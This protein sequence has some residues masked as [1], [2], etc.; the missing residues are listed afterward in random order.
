MKKQKKKTFINK[1]ITILIVLATLIIGIGYASV[2]SVILNINGNLMAYQYDGLFI[3][4]VTIDENNTF[5]AT[6]SSNTANNTIL[7]TSISLGN[8]LS[9]KLTMIVNVCNKYPDARIFSD[10]R[11]M[12]LTEEELAEYPDLLALYT[13]NDIII[14]KSSYSNLAG[15]VLP[16]NSCM[17]IPVTFKYSDSLS[18]ITNS[19]LTATINFKFD[20]LEKYKSNIT[21]AINSTTGHFDNKTSNLNY[22][23]TIT[24]N[25]TY[26]VKFNIFGNSNENLLLS[27]TKSN[28]I[29]NGNSSSTTTINLSPAKEIYESNDP[30]SIDI[31]VQ[32]VEPIELPINSFTINI[33]TFGSL[34]K[35]IIFG[36]TILVTT[37]PN[38]SQNITT[39]ENSGLFKTSDE[40]GDTY[41][42]RGVVTNNYV[43]F[44]NKMWRIVRINGDGT[45]RLVLDSSAGTSVFSSDSTST[46]N[47]GYMYGSTVHA[48]TNNSAIKT[49]LENW[50][51]NNLQS[52][53]N[54]IDKDAIFWQDRTYNS[55]TKVYAGWER[56]VN[57]SPTLVASTVDDMFSVTTTKGNGKLTK[58]IG[59]LTADE[60]VLAGGTTTGATVTGYGTAYKNTEYYLYTGDYPTYGFW[61]MT[62]RRVGSGATNNHMILSK[63]VAV[64]WSEPVVTTQRYVRPVIN[65]KTNILFK[66][67]GTKT[68]PYFI[69]N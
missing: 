29:V 56:M 39:L 5:N 36:K 28:I 45:Y 40:S 61:T 42:Y 32:V 15:T 59:L 10:L 3:S 20:S 62:P 13:N 33:S 51:T 16:S 34:L 58:P 50:Y 37:Q 7:N 14:D 49:Y 47:L 60:V 9:S 65:L 1:K 4:S 66:G 23:I 2:N 27:G 41:Y 57:N 24:N 25:N 6:N 17:D 11:Y 18:S 69:I 12:D 21:Y 26:A 48:N 19:E 64:I 46:Y 30:V 22:N 8:D 44:A 55:S 43:S 67:S 38:F 31:N 63:E 54:Y 68:D 53:D 35:D 52:Y